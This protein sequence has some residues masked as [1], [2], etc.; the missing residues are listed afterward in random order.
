M[1][2]RHA[3]RKHKVAALIIVLVLVAVVVSFYLF[4]MFT[5]SS[6]ALMARPTLKVNDVT[7]SLEVLTTLEAQEK[8]LSGR[9]SLAPDQM[10][11]FIFN[12]PQKV[13]IWM[14]GML[15]P[16]DIIWLSSDFKVINIEK[17]VSP[18]TYPQAFY[19]KKPAAY[20]LEAAA[21]T[22]DYAGIGTSS[23]FTFQGIGVVY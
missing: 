17:N 4:F 22:F 9:K 23:I 16:I 8:G 15:F 7:Y 10:M 20:V 11:L 3:S 19:P 6:P 1:H 5:S 2:I 18:D 21:G 14:K 12:P 13:G